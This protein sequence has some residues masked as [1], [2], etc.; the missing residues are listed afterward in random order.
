MG[1]SKMK[2]MTWVSLILF[3]QL[4]ICV[5][6]NSCTTAVISGRG[7]TD[8]RPILFKQRDTKNLD[9]RWVYLTEGKY[10]CIGLVN[11]DDTLHTKIWGGCNSTGF[12][13]MNAASYNLNEG[14]TSASK[15]NEGHVMKLALQTCATLADFEMLLDN[16]PKPMGLEAN[17]GVIDA[18]GGAAYY[19]TSNVDYFKYDANDPQT[20]PFGYIIRTNYSFA[21]DQ[22]KGAGYIRFAA[23]ET[24]FYHAAATH[25]L[26]VHFLLTDVSRCL[27]HGL[28]GTDLYQS[29]PPDAHTPLFVPF[30]DYIPRYSSAS[31]ILV[32]GTRQGESPDFTTVWTLLGFPLCSVAMPLWITGGKPLPTL[33]TTDKTGKAPLCNKALALKKKCFPI[34]RGSGKNYI[35]LSPVINREKTGI[36]QILAPLENRLIE[37]T[38]KKMADW[39]TRGWSAREIQ[40]YYQWL[41]REI[42]KAYH[43]QFGL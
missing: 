12:A 6:L 18:R 28:T 41:D 35:N 20:A 38:Q 2:R 34:T 5:E 7:T 29:M 31:V 27:T 11:S 3:G 9:N 24:L 13:I 39:R 40:K 26:N 30:Q 32:K 14:D 1:K 23:A 33:L 19:E 37:T 42:R 16:L 15:D 25:N 36:I 17:F 22:N 43:E 21:R 8:G 10:D 4:I